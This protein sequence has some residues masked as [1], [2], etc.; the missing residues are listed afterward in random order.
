MAKTQQAMSEISS[1]SG[2]RQNVHIASDMCLSS[3]LLLIDSEHLEKQFGL[4]A[5]MPRPTLLLV[6][7]SRAG[8]F[9]GFI[10]VAV[11]LSMAL[12]ELR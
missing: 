6:F 7:P 11:L 8:L 10:H 3:L 5:L 12:L 9:Y 2:R 1:C 4:E